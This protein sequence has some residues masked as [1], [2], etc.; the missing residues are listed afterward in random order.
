MVPMQGVPS[1]LIARNES[2]VRKQAQALVRH[3]P[4]NVEKADLIQVGL[5]AVAQAALSFVWDGDHDS[6]AGREAFVRYARQRVKGAMLDELRQMD[7]LSRTQRRQIKVLQIARER[8]RGLNGS[9]PRLAELAAVCKM[10]IDEVALL[11]RLAASSRTESIDGGGDSGFAE[12]HHPATER[13][14][15]EARVDTAIVM[16]HL[17]AFF[18]KLP[19]QERQVIDAYLGVG[20]SPVK[21]AASLQLSPSRIS[22]MYQGLLRRLAARFGDA[23]HQRSTDKLSWRDDVDTMVTAHDADTG[24]GGLMEEVLVSPAERFGIRID[25]PPGTRW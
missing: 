23:P 18:A 3:L 20:L 11:E 25:I 14:E 7:T 10:D 12:Q 15:V 4:A 9:E 1:A 13:D 16:R 6:D 21:L 8:W 17:E 24:W 5:I 22:Q 19:A 2:W